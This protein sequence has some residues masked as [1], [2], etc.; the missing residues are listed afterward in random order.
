MLKTAFLAISALTVFCLHPA[1]A[2]A[3]ER[4]F[5]GGAWVMGKNADRT[6]IRGGLLSYDTGVFSSQVYSGVVINGEV[7]LRSPDFLAPIGS[8]RPYFGADIA[9]ADDAVH[10]FY[11]GLTWD[12]YVTE[13]VYLSGS[14]GGSINTAEEVDNPVG[15]KALGSNVLFHLGVGIGYDITDDLTV[16]LYADHFSNANLA[17]HNNGAENAGLRF[18]YRF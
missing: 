5:F 2:S 6:E 9:L 14:L 15:Y 12:T 3:E 18:G 17:D 8:P 11:A 1:N 4:T 10:F 16:Q 13:K 7:V